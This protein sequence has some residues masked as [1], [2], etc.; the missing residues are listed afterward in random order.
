[1]TSDFRMIASMPKVSLGE[2][3]PGMVNV[4][5]Y[6]IKFG[7]KQHNVDFGTEELSAHTSSAISTFQKFFGLPDT[8]IL[9]E[10]T[11]E[12]MS[13]P[14]CSMPDFPEHEFRTIGAWNRRSL[15]YAFGPLT[16]QAV[17]GAVAQDAVRNA[18]HT[19]QLTNID[20]RF[21]EVSQ[22]QNPDILVEWRPANDPDLDMRGGTL[23][24]ADFPPGFWIIVSSLP[25]P[26]HFDDI[27]HTWNIGSEF[28]IETVAL[29]EIGHCLGLLHEPSVEDAVMF[30]AYS[31][32]RRHLHSD[33]LR[34]LRDLYPPLLP[35]RIRGL[36]P[37]LHMMMHS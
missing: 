12:A 5:D 31:G 19:W 14:R 6:L 17:G 36:E 9:D 26:I 10:K 27:E 15:S 28:D 23:A 16:T 29:H 7:Y 11:R 30:P 24:H 25:L 3:H 35:R 18:F 22:T 1:M 37:V 21:T 2:S 8:G 4:H 13:R 34:G 33:D 32:V 20:L